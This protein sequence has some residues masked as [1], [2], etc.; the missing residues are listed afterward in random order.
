MNLLADIDLLKNA[1]DRTLMGW[2]VVLSALALVAV[3]Y[4]VWNMFKLARNQVKLAL[5]LEE[6]LKRQR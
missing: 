5:M 6:L 2:S 3:V 4:V 1:T